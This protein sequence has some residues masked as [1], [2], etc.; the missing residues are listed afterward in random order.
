[1][2]IPR[3][4][5]MWSGPRNVSTAMMRS[6]ENRPDCSVIDEP[7]YACYLRESGLDHPS[8]AAI[9]ASQSSDRAEVIAQLLGDCET[10]LMY[11][12]HMTHHMPVGCDL[13]WTRHL[14]HVFLIRSP[15]A[16]IASYMKKMPRIA[17][18]DIGVLRQRSLF[19][20]IRALTGV[21]PIVVDSADLL[22]HPRAMLA[23]LCERL[24]VPFLA[25]RMTQWPRGPRDS[26]GV[27]ASHWYQS[28]LDSTGF[29]AYRDPEELPAG[30]LRNLAE[31]LQ[32][33]YDTMAAERLRV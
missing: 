6:W 13:Q 23:A 28:V 10:P 22:R 5:A 9:L 31:E 20:E 8:R 33:A 18:S 17:E 15:Q 4:I 1:M 27:W 29:N 26:D 16:V 19:E 21:T 7:F 24:N 30:L 12:K 11:Q 14:Q 32:P 25:S 3:R 2:M